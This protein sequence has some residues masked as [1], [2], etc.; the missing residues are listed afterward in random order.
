MRPIR[1]LLCLSYFPA[2]AA[3]I[4]VS[5]ACLEHLIFVFKTNKQNVNKVECV[6]VRGA[7]WSIGIYEPWAKQKSKRDAV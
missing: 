2:D 4:S 5:R 7:F 3:H 6:P 1:F